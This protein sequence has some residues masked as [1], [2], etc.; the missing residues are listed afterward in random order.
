M[1]LAQIPGSTS[2]GPIRCTRRDR[3]RAA[4]SAKFLQEPRLSAGVL[5]M[6]TEDE[7]RTMD[8]DRIKGT[9]HQLKGAVKEKGGKATGDTKLESEGKA[10][11]GAGKV[12]NTVGGAKDA[13][14]G[15]K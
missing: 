9:A 10:E 5:I 8:K 3:G 4:G 14:R 11:K 13:L 1:L 12:Q 2:L 7:Q 15:K 6:S